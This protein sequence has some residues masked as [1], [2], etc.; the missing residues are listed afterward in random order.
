LARHRKLCESIT[1]FV[2]ITLTR[3]FN[4]QLPASIMAMTTTDMGGFRSGFDRLFNVSA[5]FLELALSEL[6]RLLLA[7][8]DPL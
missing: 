8:L 4:K 6:M 3:T 2:R 5:L 7:Q 1:H